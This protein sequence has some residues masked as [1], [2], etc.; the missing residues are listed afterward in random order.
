MAGEIDTVRYDA[1]VL[2]GPMVILFH[3]SKDD[4]SAPHEIDLRPCERATFTGPQTGFRPQREVERVSA[5]AKFACLVEVLSRRSRKD[6]SQLF[7]GGN[8]RL[9]L[10]AG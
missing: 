2:H 7:S 5:M 8:V 10:V 4:N 9:P 1:L 3:V 6:H